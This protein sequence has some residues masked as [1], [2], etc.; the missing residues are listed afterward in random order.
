MYRGRLFTRLLIARLNRYLVSC[1]RRK[2]N[3]LV[4][5]KL[6]ALVINVYIVYNKSISLEEK[7]FHDTI[8]KHYYYYEMFSTIFGRYKHSH[9]TLIIIITDYY[10]VCHIS[11]IHNFILR[12][13]SSVEL[14]NNYSI[15]IN[16]FCIYATVMRSLLNV[17]SVTDC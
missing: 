12:G 1:Y 15:L 9:F 17:P 6:I 7:K 2:Y 14:L 13:L 11:T 5:P 4:E 8:R 16:K 3:K 10:E